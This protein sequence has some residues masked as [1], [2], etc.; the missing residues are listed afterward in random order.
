MFFQELYPQWVWREFYTASV[1][2]HPLPPQVSFTAKVYRIPLCSTAN[3][4]ITSCASHLQ[5]ITLLLCVSLEQSW[6]GAGCWEL[7]KQRRK[8]VWSGIEI[9][10]HFLIF[11]HL[12]LV[13]STGHHFSLTLACSA[14]GQHLPAWRALQST[15]CFSGAGEWSTCQKILLI[16]HLDQL[17]TFRCIKREI[18]VASPW[19]LQESSYF[20][21]ILANKVNPSNSSSWQQKVIELL[22]TTVNVTDSWGHTIPCEHD[23]DIVPSAFF[24][25]STI[26][27]QFSR[28]EGGIS[29]SS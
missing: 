27:P 29:C 10:T 6:F 13:L 23:N 24:H 25:L 22:Y 15:C 7:L 28:W 16:V 8:D 26:L 5:L 11:M 21:L 4:F 20:F 2:S 14:P 18:K 3:G 19:Q 1:L 9:F 17:L 12:L